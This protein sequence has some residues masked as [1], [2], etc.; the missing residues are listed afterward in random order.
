MIARLCDRL[1]SNPVSWAVSWLLKPSHG[2]LFAILLCSCSEAWGDTLYFIPQTINGTT[3]YN[4]NSAGNWFVKELVNGTLTTVNAG[5]LPAQADTVIINT[6]VILPSNG[7][8]SIVDLN[9]GG[10]FSAGFVGAGI[11]RADTLNM[12]ISS[13]NN[14][15]V[16]V[17][18]TLNVTGPCLL[19]S[20]SLTIDSGAVAQVIYQQDNSSSFNSGLNLESG[21]TI[22]NEGQLTLTDKTTIVNVDS[23]FNIATETLN[24]EPNALFNSTGA[25]SV[26]GLAIDNGGTFRA[27]S[28]TLTLYSD[29][30]SSTY[31]NNNFNGTLQTLISTAAIAV[32][33]FEVASAETVTVKGPGLTTFNFSPLTIN[34]HFNVGI[35]DANTQQLDPGN[36]KLGDDCAVSGSGTLH[37]LGTSSVAST[38]ELAGG[39]DGSVIF[40]NPSGS[41]PFS[42]IVNI[43]SFASLN[44]T[45]NDSCEISGGTINNSGTTTMSGRFGL[46]SSGVFN[47]LAGGVF[48]FSDPNYGGIG[49][50]GSTGKFNNAGTFA[51][52]AGVNALATDVGVAFV[53]TGTVQVVAGG[54]IDF[55]NG[56]F[57]QNSGTTNLNGG[58][59]YVPD[60]F[61]LNGG[62]LN[63]PGKIDGAY[64]DYLSETPGN[65]VNNDGT[66]SG[67]ATPGLLTVTGNYTQG[68]NGTLSIPVGG[69]VA[70]TGY[71]QL[72]VNGTATLNGALT[73]TLTGGYVP[74]PAGGLILSILTTPH[75]I[76]GNF[77]TATGQSTFTVSAEAVTTNPNSVTVT[78][79]PAAVSF[80]QWETN[81]QIN[82]SASATPE[83]DG[84]PTLLKYLYDIDPTKKMTPADRAALP[85]LGTDTTT[86]VDST[87]LTL[88][89]RKYALE[90][91]VAVNVQTSPDLKTWSIVTPDVTKQTGTDSVTGDPIME[92][93][94][95]TTT[96][97]QFIRLGFTM[98]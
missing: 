88:T 95:K 22:F 29:G 71:G 20:A 86:T 77:S 79:G 64:P 10:E 31:S 82:S 6:L 44:V 74:P 33:G 93:E 52:T 57:V 91:G 9:P 17:T 18:N 49:G 13:I 68:T 90:T 25:A 39:P 30:W 34:G 85:V 73:L 47:N 78:L 27:D 28:G 69:T 80:S 60:N 11:F 15:V 48:N 43:D 37:V 21:S 40:G 3:N 38:L 1:P 96:P 42:G 62:T 36:V 5:G 32:T 81:H 87:Y 16:E 61:T 23:A 97:V 54:G 83:N 98:P 94:V 14:A 66:V 19:V 8:Q 12:T 26:Q 70:G 89:Y 45:G 7:H 67:G 59:I 53:N 63:G 92:V 41:S 4:W 56:S 51:Q 72:V 58:T 65:L 75:P 46:D 35:I 24:N 50:F 84:V 55:G 2:A 76:T